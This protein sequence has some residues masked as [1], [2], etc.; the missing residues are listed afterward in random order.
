M[1]HFISRKLLTRPES[2]VEG[3]HIAMSGHKAT[4]KKPTRSV[5]MARYGGE[6]ESLGPSRYV[7]DPRQ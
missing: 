3:I 6:V 5:V 2:E 4:K 1:V 7:P